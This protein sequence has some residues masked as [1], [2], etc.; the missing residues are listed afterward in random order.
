[1]EVLSTSPDLAIRLE[2]G[3]LRKLI[4][5][6]NEGALLDILAREAD[7]A[8]LVVPVG[9]DETF[10]SQGLPSSLRDAW[11]QIEHPNHSSQPLAPAGGTSCSFSA[12]V[13]FDA[14]GA[15]EW[16]VFSGIWWIR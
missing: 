14:A 13:E 12:R 10:V 5:Q 6:T 15:Q 1:V 11:I 8:G 7:A 4:R 16:T 9:A 2:V 3:R